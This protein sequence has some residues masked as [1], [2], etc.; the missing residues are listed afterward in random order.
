M[1]IMRAII[2][3]KIVLILL[4]LLAVGARSQELVD[5][6]R[7]GSY[8][9]QSRILAKKSITLT[10]GFHATGNVTIST[11]EYPLV[12]GTPTR[13]QNYVYTR[14]FRVPGVTMQNLEDYRPVNEESRSIQY[15]D[16]RGKPSQSIDIMASPGYGDIV[17]Y[18]ELDGFGR[19]TTKY[20]P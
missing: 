12:T 5:D 7:L 8:G 1:V 13:Y 3:K 18:R 17:G 6:L 19:E 14:T 11:T 10:N 2:S 15:F 20:L 16:E 4:L 9:G